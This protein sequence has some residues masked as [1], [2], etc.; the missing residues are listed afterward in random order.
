MKAKHIN[1][2][3]LNPRFKDRFFLSDG[4]KQQIKENIQIRRGTVINLFL[5]IFRNHISKLHKALVCGTTFIKL[6]EIKFVCGPFIIVTTDLIFKSKIEKEVGLLVTIKKE[7][8][9]IL[10]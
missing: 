5:E 2:H 4:V 10:I 1:H 9:W 7:S 6:L 3:I 8:L